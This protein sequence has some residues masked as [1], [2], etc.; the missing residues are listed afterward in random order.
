ML[1]HRIEWMD[2]AER[3]WGPQC[4]LK[5]SQKRRPKLPGAASRGVLGYVVSFIQEKRR[6]R[7]PGAASR[8][9]LGYVQEERRTRLPGAAS[10]GVLGYVLSFIQEKRR[11]RPHG[12]ASLGLLGYV[13]SFILFSSLTVGCQMAIP[14]GC[15]AVADR[16]EN[17][18]ATF[19]AKSGSHWFQLQV[20]PSLREGET[21][22]GDS[23]S[24][25][26]AQRSRDILRLQRTLLARERQKAS[27]TRAQQREAKDFMAGRTTRND[28][29]T[30]VLKKTTRK[31]EKRRGNKDGR[32]EL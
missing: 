12:A 11:P 13:L 10:R 20:S 3:K 9:V 25:C 14:D 22:W 2:S 1:I 8:G 6:T 17:R 28:I 21:L 24:D 5:D 4:I 7:L 18:L 15:G 29:R 30:G 26:M 27:L 23:N 19:E 16:I 32:E 31:A